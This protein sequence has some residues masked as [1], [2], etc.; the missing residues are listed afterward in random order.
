MTLQEIQ[1]A[2]NASPELKT[3]VLSSLKDD[4]M[5]APPPDVVV[6][7]KEQDEQYVT[8][9]L[10]AILPDE[11][12]KGFDQKFKPVLDQMDNIVIGLTGEQKQHNEKTADFI[13]RAIEGLKNKGG[14]PVTTAK[15][16]ELEDLLSKKE[17]EFVQQMSAHEQ[18]LFEKEI[19]WSVNSELDKLNIAVP[20]HI[21]T[22]EEKQSYVNQQKALIKNGFLSGY[23]PKKDAEGNIVFY[24]G[25]KPLMSQ[26]DGKPKT[27]GELISEKFA[28]WFVPTQH[29][30]TGTG[31]Q[32]TGAAS[33]TAGFKDKEAIHAHLKAQGLDEDS[34][35]YM[36][37]FQ[38][39]CKDN[40]IVI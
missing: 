23:T 28:P 15:V 17:S 5:T 12:Q 39:L 26:K 3:G 10:N 27:A 30:V 22:D 2:V 24:E 36:D 8:N 7:T 29:T 31:T 32:T 38:K 13:K 20:P 4:F 19:I 37:Q 6:R 9:R 35:R 16:K 25:D 14:D 18:K 40:G 1:E 34:K 21:K 33:T 11:V